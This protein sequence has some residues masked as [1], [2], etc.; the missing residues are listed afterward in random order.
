MK[1]TAYAYT[2]YVNLTWVSGFNGGPEQYFLLYTK[3]DS[4]LT[5][6]GNISDLGEGRLLHFYH[7]PLTADDEHGYVL[8]SCNRINCSAQ[9]VETKVTTHS[10]TTTAL[11]ESMCLSF[12]CLHIRFALYN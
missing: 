5:Q 6:V 2:G 4:K 7:G 12:L 11:D 10:Q 1:F 8:K 9:T 3:L